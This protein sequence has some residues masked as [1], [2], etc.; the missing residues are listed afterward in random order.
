[1]SDGG[2]CDGPAAGLGRLTMTMTNDDGGWLGRRKMLLAMCVPRRGWDG[3]TDVPPRWL[4]YRPVQN[5]VVEGT[6]RQC[7]W[8]EHVGHHITWRS[9]VRVPGQRASARVQ[10][11]P[12]D[13]AG[14]RTSSRRRRSGRGG[15]GRGKGAGGSCRGGARRSKGGCR[16]SD[17]V[18]GRVRG[19]H[20]SCAATLGLPTH[21]SFDL[22]LS[23][24]RGRPQ[25]PA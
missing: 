21:L 15:A 2:R 16:D 18:P 19:K 9:S 10:V 17:C 13:V 7:L 12:R 8:Y 14:G 1:M 20:G 22:N 5:G 11:L 6:A 24:D 23:I 4:Q 3:E 25:D